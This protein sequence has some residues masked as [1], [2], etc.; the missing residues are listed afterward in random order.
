VDAYLFNTPIPLVWLGRL[1]TLYYFLHFWVV[2][3]IV[4]VVETPRPVPDSIA[5]S[6]LTSTPAE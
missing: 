5:R 6:V 4:G 1:A 3:P 2:M